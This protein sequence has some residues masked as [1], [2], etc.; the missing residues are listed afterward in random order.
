MAPAASR[1][2]K[3]SK[4]AS[5][6]RGVRPSTSGA[7]KA[8]FEVLSDSDRDMDDE[9]ENEA[10]DDDNVRGYRTGK[11]SSSSNSKR[12]VAHETVVL[13]SDDDD[14]G[15]DTEED[16]FASQPKE[17]KRQQRKQADTQRRRRPDDGPGREADD[18]EDDAIDAERVPPAL[19]ARMLHELFRAQERAGT[20]SRGPSPPKKM[21]REA[22]LLAARYIDL[23]VRETVARAGVEAEIA[24]RGRGGFLEVSVS[25]YPGSWCCS[26]GLTSGQVEDLE[27]VIPQLML[28]F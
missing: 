5:G 4:S 14:D 26:R 20:G 9:D 28:D 2:T 15:D 8:A 3:P 18:D 25:C 12:K 24:G 27:K 10:Y 19:V 17:D 6:R 23:F 1:A 13:D 16:P 21:T 11:Q 7:G 22:A